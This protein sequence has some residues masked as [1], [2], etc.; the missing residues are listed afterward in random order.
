M[1]AILPCLL[2]ILPSL[3]PM[4][5]TLLS[6]HYVPCRTP[7]GLA[8]LAGWLLGSC[9]EIGVVP[10]VSFCV[11]RL[12]PSRSQVHPHPSKWSWDKELVSS[13]FR[14][15]KYSSIGSQ[16]LPSFPTLLGEKQRE[17]VSPLFLPSLRV[18]PPLIVSLDCSDPWRT[19]AK[20]ILFPL[21]GQA[22]CLPVT[23][24]KEYV[25]RIRGV[26]EKPP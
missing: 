16:T 9:V 6:P 13:D 2:A 10:A 4:T 22:G 21:H 3:H 15:L 25:T 12:G 8:G 5:C 20:A 1:D 26:R 18:W 19:R 11:E 23:K 17:C 14:H 24:S 7:H